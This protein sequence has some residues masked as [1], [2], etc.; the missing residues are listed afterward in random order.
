[1]GISRSNITVN[2]LPGGHSPLARG[3]SPHVYRQSTATRGKPF[4][5][6]I[7]NTP[8]ILDPTVRSRPSEGHHAPTI[9]TTIRPLLPLLY[10]TEEGC[11][12]AVPIHP[13]QAGSDRHPAI[14]DDDE[15][16]EGLVISLFWQLTAVRSVSQ[17]LGV[18]SSSQ[19][20]YWVGTD[21]TEL[22]TSLLRL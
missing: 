17:L 12:A 15:V 16:I 2:M 13:L 19:I 9:T 10:L 1:M 8:L 21:L 3:S 6:F 7:F 18:K 4:P 14:S 5:F 20:R 11:G 22:I